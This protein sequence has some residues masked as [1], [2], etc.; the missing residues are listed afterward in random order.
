MLGA[1]GAPGLQLLLELSEGVLAVPDG[2]L[3]APDGLLLPPGLA[4]VVLLHL[5]GHSGH[6]P[7]LPAQHVPLLDQQILLLDQ[8][9]LLPD[10]GLLLLGQGVPLLCELASGGVV[11]LPPHDLDLFVVQAVELVVEAL[12]LSVVV[13]QILDLFEV[14]P[15]GQLDLLLLAQHGH[16]LPPQPLDLLSQRVIGGRVALLAAQLGH[17]FHL[18]LEAGLPLLCVLLLGP[19]D[20]VLCPQLEAGRP[21]VLLAHDR[22]INL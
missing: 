19:E 1:L 4:D 11:G 3:L 2:L 6:L 15:A 16:Q 9:L 21:V 5:L 22:I 17:D 7:Q 18:P 14:G 10:Q 12:Q 8:G 20:L 13:F